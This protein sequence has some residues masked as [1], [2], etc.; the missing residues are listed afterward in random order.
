MTTVP[1]CGIGE[2]ADPDGHSEWLMR[3]PR[4][5]KILSKPGYPQRVPNPPGNIKSHVVKS[6]PTMGQGIF[7]TR[8]IPMGEII[9]A[10]QPL[11]VA[12]HSLVPK[13]DIGDGRTAGHNTMDR[14]K[15]GLWLQM[16]ME[17]PIYRS[18]VQNLI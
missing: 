8:D 15:S 13:K 10:K 4:K 11:L 2:P 1:S 14:G 9:F 3:G 16:A 5:Q 6:T 17:T 7:A 12:P 18:H